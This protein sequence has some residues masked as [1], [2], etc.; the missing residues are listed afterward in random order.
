MPL[1]IQRK[2]NGKLETIDEVEDA[3]EAYRLAREYNLA[4]QT[5]THYVSKKACKSWS[6]SN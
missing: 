6:E 1:Y 4:D 5:A 3:K 2:S